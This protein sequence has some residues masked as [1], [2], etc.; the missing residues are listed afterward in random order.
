VNPKIEQRLREV[1]KQEEATRA[2]YERKHPVNRRAVWGAVVG[3][4]GG[5]LLALFLSDQGVHG[6]VAG[7]IVAVFSSL[8][9]YLPVA[10]R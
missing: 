8:A 5:F 7:T 9:V 3:L 2:A 1:T 4:L 6:A 10:R